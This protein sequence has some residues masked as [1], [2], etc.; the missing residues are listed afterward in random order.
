MAV[1]VHSPISFFLQCSIFLLYTFSDVE[2]LVGAPGLV[3]V[4]HYRAANE[5][6]RQFTCLS[7][8]EGTLL[9]LGTQAGAG[10]SGV[11]HGTHPPAQSRR[12]SQPT[13]MPRF[14]QPTLMFLPERPFLLSLLSLNATQM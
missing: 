3:H 7:R 6:G 14:P 8:Q 11:T 10:N 1:E 9:P 2:F 13:G 12:C 4:S 5:E